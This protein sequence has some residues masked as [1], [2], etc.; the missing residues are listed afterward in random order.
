M[1]DNTVYKE[2]IR[3]IWEKL[4]K[5]MIRLGFGWKWMGKFAEDEC[6]HQVYKKLSGL[7][8]KRK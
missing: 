4:T 1:K 3:H 2:I 5:E 8:P 7:Q 6:N